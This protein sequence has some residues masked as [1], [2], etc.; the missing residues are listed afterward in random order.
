MELS[1]EEVLQILKLIESSSFDFLQL[2]L[3]DL[4][5]TVAKGGYEI[6]GANRPAPGAVTEPAPSGGPAP[7][8]IQDEARREPRELEARASEAL[9]LESAVPIRAPMVG[10]FYRAPEPGAPPFVEAGDRV[11]E[12][13]TVGLIEVMKV[14]SAVKAGVRGV[15]LEVSVQN[16][17][18]VEYGQTL[19]LVR[20]EEG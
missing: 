17:Q 14:F 9:L 15:I 13:T 20:P 3:G 16:S 2:E 4:K 7:D 1:E 5:L 18:F 8:G 19:F 10:T 11:Q 6:G 12:E